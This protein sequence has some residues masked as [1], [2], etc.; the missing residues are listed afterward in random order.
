MGVVLVD[1]TG[2]ALDKAFQVFPGNRAAEQLFRACATQWRRNP[3][4][5]ALEGLDYSGVE[6]AA[7]LVRITLTPEL[8]E[9]LQ[10]IEQGAMGARLDDPDLDKLN[11]I[12]IEC[13]EDEQDDPHGYPHYG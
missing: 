9:Q 8:F 1:E 3:M 2:T 4:T 12:H 7:R 13:H 5:G 11:I 6:T 10:W